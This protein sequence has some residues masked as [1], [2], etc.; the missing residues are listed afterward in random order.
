[1]TSNPLPT[2]RQK[3]QRWSIKYN[4][5]VDEIAKSKA[6][7]EREE[8]EK[9]APMQI[10]SF[11]VE[12]FENNTFSTITGLGDTILRGK[13]SIMGEERDQLWMSVFRFGFGRNVSG[14][15]FS[16]GLHLTHQDDVSY[17]GEIYEEDTAKEEDC[18]MDDPCNWKG[19]KFEING[20][21]MLGVGLEPCSIARFTMIEKTEEDTDD[22]E[23]D[24]DTLDDLPL[25][26]GSFE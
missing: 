23:D 19:T 1:M 22:E 13:W 12:L 17:W 15:T 26:I 10:K 11:E 7:K 14:S 8:R 5:Y 4:A 18:I 9:N 25:A 3:R 24:E 6:E 16:E 21:V 2:K 20:A